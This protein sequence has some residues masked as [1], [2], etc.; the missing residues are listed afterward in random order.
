MPSHRVKNFLRRLTRRRKW[1][2]SNRDGE[3]VLDHSASDDSSVKSEPEDT[4]PF[5][6]DITQICETCTKIDLAFML[7]HAGKF[8]REAS[9]YAYQIG[10][11]QEI[12]AKAGECQL[13]QAWLQLL[14]K[15]EACADADQT[16]QSIFSLQP[17]TS[18]SRMGQNSPYSQA[19]YLR[20]SQ[21]L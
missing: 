15:V 16:K 3:S 19:V 5:K 11:F 8:T 17:S 12:Q 4:P 14:P 9:K 6:S 18:F 21:S 1:K 13:C 10:T 7:E 20:S 2:S